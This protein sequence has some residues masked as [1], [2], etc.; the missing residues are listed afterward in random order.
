M[1]YYTN[2]SIS[3]KEGPVEQYR[4]MLADIDDI[5]GCGDMSALESC[6][7]K[8]YEYGDDLR[9]LSEKYPDITF[10]VNGDG[11]DPSDLWQEFWRAG[12]RFREQVH[13]VR[14][15]EIKDKLIINK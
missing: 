1:G 11:E 2:F 12:N 7:A 10:R 3:L 15:E 4:K 14:Y 5:L 6:C 9:K 13:F 8:W